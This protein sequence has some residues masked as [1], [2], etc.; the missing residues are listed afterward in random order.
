MK[1]WIIIAFVAIVIMAGGA[2]VVRSILSEK[3]AD[4]AAN[5]MRTAT[6][7][8][9]DI[10]VAVDATGTI[11][12]LVVVEVRSKASGAITK[13]AVEEGNRLKVG[14]L[15]AEIEKTY[16]QADVDQEEANLKTA[17]ARL[18]QAKQNIDLQKKQT[19][20]QIKQAKEALKDAEIRLDKLIEEI[21]LE[22]EANARAVKEAE[23]DLEMAKLRLKQAEISR[24]ESVKR[25]EASVTQAKSSLDLAQQEYERYQTLF[26][27]QFVSK[28]E[29]E[30]SKAKLDSAKA[31]YDSAVEQLKIVEKPSSAEEIK[32]AR[33][34]VTKSE[35]ALESAKHRVKQETTREKELK[36]TESQ[37]ED[38]K[39]TLELVK[40]N[41]V[42]VELKEKDLEAAQASVTKS[43]VALKAAKDRLADTVVKAPIAGTIL[44]KE[45]EEGQVITSSMSSMA[46]AGTLLVT[47]ANLDN[48]YVKTDVDE[49]DIGKVQSGQF[50]VITVDAFPDQTFDGTVLKIAPQGHVVQNVTSFEVTTEISN[51]TRILKPGMNVSVKIMVAD[52][53]GIL[54][55]DN[56]AV[57]DIRGRKMAVPVVDGK[58]DRPIPIETG[59]RGWDITEIISGLQEGDVVMIATPGQNAGGLPPWMSERMKNPM[60]NFQRMSRGGRRPGGPPPR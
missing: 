15:I 57:M 13:L 12:P 28:A 17:K 36:L 25:A 60:S 35:L 5:Q 24:P 45:V 56:E 34:S 39:S 38:A 3:E 21:E 2:I 55:L 40:A 58:P 4:S 32:L 26:K 31:S 14:D 33:L 42:Q 41:A 27:Q 37:V 50:V 10:T 46:S 29:V 16:T 43:E 8:R 52:R 30:S 11:E 19:E 23:N 22:K 1:K 48:V 54:V 44:Q 7:K 9:G 49:T 53:R 51:P 47:M 20:I 59:V 18:T 6:V